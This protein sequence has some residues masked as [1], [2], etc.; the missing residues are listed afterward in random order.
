MSF[1]SG[2]QLAQSNPAGT[3]AVALYTA[4]MRTEVTLLVIANSTGSAAAYS[5][6]HDDDGTT[7]T[8]ATALAEVVSL[9]ANTSVY[10][11]TSPAPGC[12][13]VVKAGGTLAV[14]TG[15]GSALTFTLY[16]VTEARR[17]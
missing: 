2:S 12:G 9:A 8:A 4:T 6:Y 15:T 5:I 3:S 1:A 10:L 11:L 13:L 16:G 7:Y 17:V 14:K